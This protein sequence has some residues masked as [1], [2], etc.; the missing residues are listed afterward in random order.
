MGENHEHRDDTQQFDTGVP[1]PY[2]N[3]WSV[4]VRCA[5]R[6][7]RRCSPWP[8]SSRS[9][10]SSSLW[11]LFSFQILRFQTDRMP[12]PISPVTNLIQENVT[13][14]LSSKCV[15]IWTLS[16]SSNRSSEVDE[17]ELEKLDLD[18]S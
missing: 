6:S 18:S 14:P 2:L 12:H 15:R 7:Y 3:F 10:F 11:S 16:H 13:S 17:L 5:W 9:Q 8:G 1:T 4:P